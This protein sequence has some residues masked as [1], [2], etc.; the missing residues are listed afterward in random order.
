MTDRPTSHLE[1]FKWRYLSDGSSDSAIHVM[2]GY[3]MGFSD[4]ANR[5]ALFPVRSN[6]RWRLAAIFENSNS[7]ISAIG[8]LIHIMFVSGLIYILLSKNPHRSHILGSVCLSTYC[9]YHCSHNQSPT[10]YYRH[11]PVKSFRDSHFTRLHESVRHCA[12]LQFDE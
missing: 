8:H 7:A 6:P 5:M 4:T 1:N 10:V 3:R 11:A 12:P 2:F 9:I